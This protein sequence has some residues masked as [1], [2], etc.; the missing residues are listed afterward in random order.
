MDLTDALLESLY[1][2]VQGQAAVQWLVSNFARLDEDPLASALIAAFAA[3]EFAL[4]FRNPGSPVLAGEDTVKASN[5]EKLESL[6]VAREQTKGGPT[7]GVSSGLPVQ[8][9]D[10][11]KLLLELAIELIR[12]YFLKT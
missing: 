6:L 2:E 4:D 7:G 9:G 10:F 5:R 11:A 12:K 3:A 8:G 1:P